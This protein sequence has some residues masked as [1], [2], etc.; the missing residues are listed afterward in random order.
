MPEQQTPVS[1][2]R[3][4]AVRNRTGLSR[5]GLYRLIAERRFPRPVPISRRAVGWNSALV[6][7][8]VAERIAQA[9]KV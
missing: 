7:R 9:S 4:D 2:L 5:S 8:W 1:I 6:D 3:L